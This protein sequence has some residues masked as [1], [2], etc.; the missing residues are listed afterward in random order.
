MKTKFS[1]TR[2]LVVLLALFVAAPAAWSQ[3]W[4]ELAPKNN[5]GPLHSYDM[6]AD[7]TGHI[8]YFGG[9]TGAGSYRNDT[10]SW[11]GS[12]WT[13]L[14][15]PVYPEAREAHTLSFDPARNKVVL[16]SGWN[17]GNYIK[18]TWEWDSS[19]WTNV[20]PATLPPPRDYSDMTYDPA[21]GTTI[22][23]GGH[24]WWESVNGNGTYGDFWSWDGTTW[25][26]LTPPNLPQSRYGHSM[27]YD[28][29][30]GTVILVGG[31]NETPGYPATPCYDMWEWDGTDWSQISPASLPAPRILFAMVWDEDRSR[32]VIHGGKDTVANMLYTDTWEWDGTSWTQIWTTG[33]EYGWIA[34]AY[35]TVRNEVLIQGGATTPDKSTADDKTWVFTTNPIPPAVDIKAN[36]LDG[37]VM[38]SSSQNVQ[39]DI[40]V[41]A[42]DGLGINMDV[43]VV[44]KLG[45][46]AYY[47]NNGSA[48]LPGVGG[49][50]Y[51]GPL[52]DITNVRVLDRTLPIATYY[53]YLAVDTYPNFAPTTTSLVDWDVVEIQVF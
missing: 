32:V 11:D 52:Q 47:H 21:T 14:S 6:V 19:G 7:G 2:L 48:W 30:R 23:F 28:P 24:D 1:D 25:T 45:S 12:D 46:G 31:I 36:G 8:I 34:G 4:Y 22:M 43:L 49:A 20:T 17:G 40:N 9:A 3:G 39:L 13:K 15:T 29:N 18:D 16:F 41:E 33:P 42:R 53:A 50:Y 5:P 10:W 26:Q 38:V 35:D 44:I 51:T 37:P 27:I